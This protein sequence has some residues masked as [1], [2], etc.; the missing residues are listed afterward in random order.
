LKLNR[1]AWDDYIAKKN[2]LL[3]SCFKSFE[4]GLSHYSNRESEDNRR[5][6]I[7]EVDQAI[8][9]FLKGVLLERGKDPYQMQFQTLLKEVKK[10]GLQLSDKEEITIL[11]LHEKRNACQHEGDIPG[12]VQTEHLVHSAARFLL[13]KAEESLGISHEQVVDRV[14]SILVMGIKKL[15]IDA[16]PKKPEFLESLEKAAKELLVSGDLRSAFAQISTAA[17]CAVESLY[18]AERGPPLTIYWDKEK[19]RIV[20]PKNSFSPLKVI[21]REL[22]SIVSDFQ[23]NLKKLK[24]G[25]NL[26]PFDLSCT[27][28]LFPLE[29]AAIEETLFLARKGILESKTSERLL[30][31]LRTSLLSSLQRQFPPESK[32]LIQTYFDTILTLDSV[33]KDFYFLRGFLVTNKVTREAWEK[34]IE[35]CNRALHELATKA[36]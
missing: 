30:K 36:E 18:L 14:P 25:E 10:Q 11:T 5:F 1:E 19:K 28:M 13:E 21:Q 23:P 6:C 2:P 3:A 26:I 22:K 4:H 33:L 8:E 9:L 34:F 20:S 12:T 16:Q 17:R 32:R 31:I 24:L 27:I 7:V 35:E 29:V 15:H